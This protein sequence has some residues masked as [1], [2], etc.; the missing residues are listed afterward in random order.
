MAIDLKK[1]SRPTNDRPIIC[2]LFGEG[3]MGKTTLAAMFPAPVF[4]RTEDGTA[5]ISG[6][7][8]AL[9]FDVAGSTAEVFEAI[10]AL[11]AGGHDRKTLVIDSVTQ[12]EKMAV[13]EILDSEPNPKAKSMPA[14]HGGYGKAFGILDAKHQELREA[15]GYLA[16]DCGM[17]VVFLMHAS[18]EELELPDADK[19][20]RYTVALHKNKQY[21]CS[22]HYTNN[23]DL[24]AFIRLRTNL[25]GAEGG[26]KRAISDGEREIICFP[27]ASNVSKNRFG[28]TTPMP[29]DLT[30]GNPFDQFVAK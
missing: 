6:H 5:S 9:L 7:D 30:I 13:R 14:A 11:I 10:E 28:I 3:G 27:V 29:F 25:R 26:K 16:S 17:N 22:H 18:I 20:S 19:Y 24:V 21:D 4:I 15:A 8:D 2:T 12:F 1:L 23:A